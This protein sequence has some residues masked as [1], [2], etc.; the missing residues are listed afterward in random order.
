MRKKLDNLFTLFMTFLCVCAL[1]WTMYGCVGG[2]DV[3]YDD[4]YL[5]DGQCVL[6]GGTPETAGVDK[7]K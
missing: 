7:E 4:C 6:G 1:A 3:V 5:V 2:W